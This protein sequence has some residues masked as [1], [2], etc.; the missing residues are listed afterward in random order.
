ME[1]IKG[2]SLYDYVER[3]EKLKEE[4]AKTVVRAL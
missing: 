1:Y 4:Q 2:E 3:V